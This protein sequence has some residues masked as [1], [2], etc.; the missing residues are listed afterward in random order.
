LE[1]CQLEQSFQWF[2]RVKLDTSTSVFSSFDSGVRMAT[3][4]DFEAA[5]QYLTGVNE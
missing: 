2:I 5:G 4:E 3:G 1:T